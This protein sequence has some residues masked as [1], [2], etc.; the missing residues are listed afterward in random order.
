[1]TRCH[2]PIDLTITSAYQLSFSHGS[3]STQDV[4]IGIG[5]IQAFQ[6]ANREL[7]N[8]GTAKYKHQ[9][10]DITLHG[11]RPSLCPVESARTR[12]DPSRQCQ[13]PQPQSA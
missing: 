8:T 2:L 5:Q 10:T 9:I 1:V 4:S 3:I 6:K 12:L 7:M 11:Y 13:H